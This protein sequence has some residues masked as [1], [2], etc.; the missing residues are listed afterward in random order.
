[1]AHLHTLS[2]T[3]TTPPFS[4][5][6]V[7][8][9]GLEAPP[10]DEVCA[11]RPI[12][13]ALLDTLLADGSQLRMLEIDWW[14]VDE[15]QVAKLAKALVNLEKFKFHLDAPFTKLVSPFGSFACLYA[16]TQI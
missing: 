6:P 9:F 15:K 2:V 5:F 7:P 1:M 11:V 12:P 8:P 3:R 14:E 4:L 10:P 16:T 13:D